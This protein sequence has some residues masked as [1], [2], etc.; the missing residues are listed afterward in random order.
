M[1]RTHCTSRYFLHSWPRLCWLAFHGDR[2]FGVIVC[3][4]DNHKGTST[5]RGYIAMLVVMTA[6]R[7]LGVGERTPFVSVFL[8]NQS[9]SSQAHAASGCS[10]GLRLCMA[11]PEVLNRSVTPL[12][13]PE[14]VQHSHSISTAA[15]RAGAGLR[16]LQPR[17]SCGAAALL[18]LF[19]DTELDARAV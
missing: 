11:S 19:L 4:A 14:Q 17:T 18:L 7:G 12:Q 5:L 10:Q 2:C 13:I 9:H 15:H 1:E 16:M 3:K 6:Y 8:L